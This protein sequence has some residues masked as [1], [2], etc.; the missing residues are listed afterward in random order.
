MRRTAQTLPVSVVHTIYSDTA[1]H[2][3]INFF[4]SVVAAATDAVTL[5]ALVRCSP[6]EMEFYK[7][8]PMRVGSTKRWVGHALTYAPSPQ[9]SLGEGYGMKPDS[10]AT[11]KSSPTHT[12]DLRAWCDKSL[13]VCIASS[14][15]DP[16]DVCDGVYCD[17]ST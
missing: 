12:K 8:T 13:A 6:P 4:V 14:R 5:V 16:D 11:D 1:R 9:A 10:C 2:R 17:T 15:S 3:D 7:L